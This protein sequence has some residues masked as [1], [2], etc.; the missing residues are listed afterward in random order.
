MKFCSQEISH[1]GSPHQGLS[2]MRNAD[3]YIFILK[4]PLS[5]QKNNTI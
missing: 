1:P 3:V 5:C 4:N 2:D